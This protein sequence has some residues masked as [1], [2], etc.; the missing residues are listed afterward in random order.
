MVPDGGEK[1]EAVTHWARSLTRSGCGQRNGLRNG[2]EG[3]LLVKSMG[4]DESPGVASGLLHTV[5]S[6][7][8]RDPLGQNGGSQG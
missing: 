8:Q 7:A 5:P 1:T 2:Q 3:P 6:T 4:V